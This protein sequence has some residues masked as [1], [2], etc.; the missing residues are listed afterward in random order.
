MKYLLTGATGF[1][2]Q[3]LCNHFTKQEASLCLLSRNTRQSLDKFPYTA[4][5][6]DWDHVSSNIDDKYLACDAVIHLAGENIAG[7]RWTKTQ[8]KRLWDSRIKSTAALVS[9]IMNAPIKPK[10]FICAS[11]IGYYGD[12]WQEEL[13]EASEKG[14]GFLADLCEEWENVCAP[15]TA[16][17]VRVVHVRSGIVLGLN[18]GALGEFVKLSDLGVLGCIGSGQQW[19]SWIH[20]NDWV[21]A[22]QYCIDTST[23]SGAVNFVS[24]SPIQQKNF[25]QILSSHFHRSPFFSVPASIAKL[26]FGGMSS[27]FLFSQKVRPQ[28]LLANGFSFSYKTL[29]AALVDL[30]PN[31]GKEHILEK[32][33]FVPIETEKIFLFFTDP[34]NLEE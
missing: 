19:M 32:F 18:E 1:L 34:Y 20:V 5:F 6:V 13:D 11:A 3:N 14:E 22:L 28:K 31:Q 8:R 33:L 17:G 23:I 12:R 2:G 26:V 15:L 4:Q 7:K 21:K 24:P 30:Y 10:V 25:M 27:L 9:S 29:D 16:A